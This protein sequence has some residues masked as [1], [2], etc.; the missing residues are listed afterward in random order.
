MTRDKRVDAYIANAPE[1]AKPI[2]VEVRK[3]VHAACPGVGETIKWRM[4]FFEYGG[5]L[6]AGM[7]AFKHH[8]SFGF[9][10]PTMRDG[11]T[12]LEGIGRF[13]K[14]ESIAD[15]PSRAAFEKL[16]KKARK[17]VDDGVAPPPRPRA[18]KKEIVVPE[19][20]ASALKKSAKARATYDAFA[21]TK[22]NEYV[23][24]INEAKREETRAQRIA[25][26]VAQLA[27]GKALHWKYGG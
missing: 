1:F 26:T 15:L 24:W 6:F 16:A 8:C 21:Y 14:V 12:S 18:V 7:S 27:E 3:R 20:L 23:K 25:T 4:P 13:G 2:L 11:D 9:W 10:H 5:K 19:D 22:R 17:L